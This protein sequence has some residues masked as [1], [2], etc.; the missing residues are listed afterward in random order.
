MGF[1][2]ERI[3]TPPCSR[4]GE[5][6]LMAASPP[7]GVDGPLL[8]LCRWCDEDSDCAAGRLVAVVLAGLDEQSI[9][10]AGELTMVWYR[11]VMASRGW[12]QRTADDAPGEAEASFD[13]WEKEL[14]AARPGPLSKEAEDRI[15]GL[16]QRLRQADTDSTE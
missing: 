5:Q 15:L 2:V 14:T 6:L 8:E 7:P 13:A 4:C 3:E 1:R 12:H 10:L 16:F 11:E 9:Q